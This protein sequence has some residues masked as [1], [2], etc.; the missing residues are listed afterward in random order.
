MTDLAS[1][2]QD[3]SPSFETKAALAALHFGIVLLAFWLFFGGGIGL[4][5]GLLGR[6]PL[7]ASTARRCALAGAALLYYVRT[8]FTMFVFVRRRMPWSEVMA[9]AGWILVI[10]ALFACFGGRNEEPFHATGFIG[11]V[12]VI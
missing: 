11:I 6:E 4:V 1:A 10:E 3:R 2:Y 7:I 12:L 8:L 9:I 5:D